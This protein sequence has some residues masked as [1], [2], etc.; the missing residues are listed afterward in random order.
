[1]DYDGLAYKVEPMQVSDSQEVMAIERLSFPT[2]WPRG[3]YRFEI[4]HNPRACYFVVR[5]QEEGAAQCEEPRRGLLAR[6]RSP[7]QRPPIVGYGG[8]WR[9]AGEAHISTLAVHPRLRR[10]G[11]GQLI[12]L[13]MIDKARSLGAK[14]ITLEVRASN[15][16]A[17]SLYRKY[18]FQVVGRRRGYYSDINED[19]VVMAVQDIDRPPY[20]IH[21]QELR[22]RLI[23][24]LK[25]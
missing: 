11:I 22:D 2:P 24:R 12:L 6:F 18:G 16:V 13:A 4:H 15:L 3:A 20:S 23:E 8:F 9:S 21:L 19:A 14:H 10:K 5:P 25:R 7:D 17:Q 1:M